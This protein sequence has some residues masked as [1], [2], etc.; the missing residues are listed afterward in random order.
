MDLFPSTS[1]ECVCFCGAVKTPELS[2]GCN[3]VL[4]WSFILFSPQPVPTSPTSTSPTPGGTLGMSK[5]DAPSMQ[6]VYILSPVSGLYSTRSDTSTQRCLMLLIRLIISDLLMKVMMALTEMMTDLLSSGRRWVWCHVTTS[7]ATAWAP[8][9]AP[10]VQRLLA[11][12]WTRTAVSSSH[13]WKEMDLLALIMTG[14]A[15]LGSVGVIRPPPMVRRR[16]QFHSKASALGVFSWTA[17]SLP[18]AFFS[19][20]L[21]TSPLVFITRS[22]VLLLCVF[23]LRHTS[24]KHW[25]HAKGSVQKLCLQ[26]PVCP[27]TCVTL[28]QDSYLDVLL[29][30][31]RLSKGLW[32]A[33]LG[34]YERK[35]HLITTYR[36]T[37]YLMSPYSRSLTHYT[38]GNLRCLHWEVSH[39]EWAVVWIRIV[40]G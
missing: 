38:A 34:S 12:T 18:P 37:C 19:P 8:S 33:R 9:L 39:S 25:S 31:G 29:P 35:K 20:F 4:E 36:K 1:P 21:Q 24:K 14:A 11:I 22:M 3:T 27:T 13:C 10:R 23:M 6:D 17:C 26:L 32:S 5:M 30:P 40:I 2:S 28:V 16:G 7:A 15:T